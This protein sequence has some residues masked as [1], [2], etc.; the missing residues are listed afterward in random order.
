M[1]TDARGGPTALNYGGKALTELGVV[2]IADLLRPLANFAV[3]FLV[4]ATLAFLAGRRWNMKS[5]RDHGGIGMVL[6]ALLTVGQFVEERGSDL[7]HLGFVGS[8]VPAVREVQSALIVGQKSKALL[9]F[10][11]KVESRDPSERAEAARLAVSTTDPDDQHKFLAMILAS[12]DGRLRQVAV[13]HALKLREG[14]TIPIRP[15]ADAMT[16]EFAR[17][18]IGATL[19]F[20]NV[21]EAS[22]SFGGGLGHS[23]QGETAISGTV[24]A[25]DVVIAT[26][27]R[28][29][30]EWFPTTLVLH[31]TD[32][33]ELEGTA[34]TAGGQTARM[35]LPLL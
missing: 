32:D 33:F 8:N 5:L 25:K 13:L 14:Q 15:D 34:T 23:G 28:I 31:V 10:Q 6:F 18:F 7:V 21:D 3:I 4:L 35:T 2:L 16:G 1:T 9:E 17:T 24:S 30:T 20:S 26:S 22:S 29:K 12:G 11:E 19:R 27:C